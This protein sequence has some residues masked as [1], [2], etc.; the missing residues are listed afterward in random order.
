MDTLL[1]LAAQN[2]LPDAL[3]RSLTQLLEPH[4]KAWASRPPPKKKKSAGS[5]DRKLTLGDGLQ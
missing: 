2:K 5:K 4:K 1:G 3:C